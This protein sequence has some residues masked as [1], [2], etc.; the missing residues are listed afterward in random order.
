MNY[1]GYSSYLGE[2]GG[3]G[4]HS[5]LFGVLSYF[6]GCSELLG[7]LSYFGGTVNSLVY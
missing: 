1:L 4:G 7:V 5:E 2:G 3:G 6:G